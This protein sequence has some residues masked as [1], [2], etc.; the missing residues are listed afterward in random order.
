MAKVTRLNIKDEE[1]YRLG[2]ELA[3]R[4][5]VSLTEVVRRSLR[6]SLEKEKARES[7]CLLM[8]KLREISDRCSSRPVLDYRSAGEILG[9]DDR[10]LPG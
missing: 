4:T 2:R 5:G 1:V 3:D 7:D 8:D 10:R 6:E 9:C